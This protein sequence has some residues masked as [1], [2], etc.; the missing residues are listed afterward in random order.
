MRRL[1]ALLMI[2]V[3]LPVCGL[4]E[5]IDPQTIAREAMDS[6]LAGEAA[7][8][9][10]RFT[11]EMQAAVPLSQ[12]EALL[13]QLTAATGAFVAYGEAQVEGSVAVLRLHMQN[14]DLLAQF[15]ITEEGKISGLY[16]NVAPTERPPASNEENLT[17]GAHNLPAI[18]TLPESASPVPAVVLVHGSGPQNRDEAIGGVAP[19]ADLAEGLASRGIAVLRYDKRTFLM[20]QGKLPVTPEAI[21]NLT[22][23]EETIEDAVAAVQLLKADPRIDPRRVFILGHSLGGR[24][25]PVIQQNG[26]DAAGL[27]LLAGAPRSLYALL[28]EQLGEAYYDKLM[29]EESLAAL[30]EEAARALDVL[31]QSGYYY[32]DEMRY[33]VLAAAKEAAAPMLILQGG[34][35]VQVRADIDFALYEAFAAENPQMDITTRLY[36]ALT[37]L[38][39]TNPDYAAEAHVEADVIEDVAAWIQAH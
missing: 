18:L 13:P 30:T 36:P 21:A 2:F 7:P 39:T 37:H 24:L 22:V 6:L 26:A 34:Q 27:I 10:D 5:Q 29:P 31:G 33:D 15:A 38:F 28:R 23:F 16:F 9:F 3:M 32:W 11:E 19:F 1:F 25:A 20:N 12:V 35:D 14:M 8:V 4:A 17:I